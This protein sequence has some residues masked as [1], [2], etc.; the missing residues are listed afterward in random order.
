MVPPRREVDT[1]GDSQQTPQRQSGGRG[2]RRSDVPAFQHEDPA[3]DEIELYT[4]VLAAVAASDGP[5]PQAELDKALGIRV[6]RPDGHRMIAVNIYLDTEAGHEAVEE[7]VSLILDSIGFEIERRY[8]PRIASWFMSMFASAKQFLSTPE[9]EKQF[10]KLERALD[11]RLLLS[12][13]AK[14]DSAQSD[15]VSKLLFALSNT[16]NALIQIGSVLLIKIDGV[17]IVRNLSQYE[18]A[19][20]ETHPTL[21]SEPVKALQQ[22]Q[23]IDREQAG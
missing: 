18:L 23:E 12:D 16:Q 19:Y 14:I 7:A 5:L 20:L 3:L 8:P 6:I 15:A 11:M 10:Q 4:D 2:I 21:L 22:L 9:A 17:P 13:Q 1:A